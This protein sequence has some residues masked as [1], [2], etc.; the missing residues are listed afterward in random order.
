MY[1]LNNFINITLMCHLQYKKGDNNR[2]FLIKFIC[3]Q[4]YIYGL[5]PVISRFGFSISVTLLQYSLLGIN[6]LFEGR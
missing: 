3:I 6:L 2:F 4:T 5:I 1:N